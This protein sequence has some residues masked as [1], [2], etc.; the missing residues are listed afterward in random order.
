MNQTGTSTWIVRLAA[1]GPGPRLAVK[2]CIDVEGLPTTVGCAVIAEKAGPARQDAAVVAAMRRSGAQIVG[3]TNLTEL[4]WSAG[5][6]N[7]WSGTPVNPADPRRLPGGSSSG[8][9][10][11]VALGEA[12]VAL[13]TDTG[14]SVRIPAACCGVVGLKTTWGRVPAGGVYPLA[15]SLDCVGPLGADVAAVELGMRLIEPGF[16]AGL[17]E[18]AVGRI[19]PAQGRAAVNPGTEAALDA[20]LDA[21]GVRAGEVAGLDFEAVERA[22]DAL[23]DAEAYQ[24]NAYLMPE[25]A[26]LGENIQR[27]M[28]EAAAITP[29]Q[30]AAAEEARASVR[31]WFM[32]QLARHPFLALPTLV[33]PP[34]VIGTR[35]PL[36]ILTMPANLTG[37]PALALPVPG[38]PAGLSASLQLIGP[39]GGEE[40]LIALGR[41][42]EAAVAAYRLPPRKPGPEQ[43]LKGVYLLGV[44]LPDGGG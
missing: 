13:G 5:G 22:A 19:R 20:A 44:Q 26:R 36:T 12:D 10:V 11:A 42:I 21:A 16:T 27:N 23:I 1:A 7:A 40:Q 14:G 15:P 29:E 25:L 43:G 28:T 37:L 24:A 17:C 4:C 35:M 2:D 6:T 34:P 9:A 31:G 41:V 38:G 39:P 3:K 18:L 8:S 30:V 32:D 33:G